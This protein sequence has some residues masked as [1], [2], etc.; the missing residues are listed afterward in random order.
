MQLDWKGFLMKRQ[1]SIRTI[2]LIAVLS[3][4]AGVGLDKLVSADNIYEQIQKFGDVLSFTDKN[5]VEPVDVSKL[6]E[7]AINGML[8]T[9]DPHSVY[10]PAKQFETVTD[11]FS[12]QFQGIG[13]SFRVLNDTITVMEPVGGGPSARLGIMS[14]D[15][16]IRINDSSAIGFTDTQVMKTLRGP[17]GTKVKVTIVRPGVKDQLNFVITRDVIP[18]V[19]ISASLMLKGDVGYVKLDR[20]S[21]TTHEE[22]ARALSKLKAEGMKRLILDLRD[23]GGGYLEEAVRLADLFLD[24]GPKD[25][26]RKIVYTKARRPELEDVYYAHTGDPY[27][28]LPLIVMINHATAS[29]SEIVS[30]AIQDWDRGLIVGETSFGKGL[31]QRQ[32]KLSDG[33]AF[34]ITIARYYTPSGRL[35][36]R[37]YEGM[38]R[39]AYQMEPFERKEKEGENVEHTHD[40]SEDSLGPVFKTASGRPVRGSGG[41]IPDY[42]VTGGSATKLFSEIF[43]RN[44]FF[45]YAKEFSEGPGLPLREKYNNNL[46]GFKKDFE[47][48]DTMLDEFMKFV[49]TKG[50]AVDKKEE[51]KDI[52]FIKARLK[53][54]IANVFFGFEGLVSVMLDVDPQIQKAL[55]LFP[56]AEKIAKLN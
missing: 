28:K 52:V 50:V 25:N 13:V 51:E 18:F 21:E 27:E 48:S 10:I 42:I 36:Q 31:V 26:P 9:L 16:I 53:G 23:D 32:M 4:G 11:Q 29:A 24:G 35:I 40:A 22:M 8:N 14:N 47:I 39:T 34:R 33:S 56:E 12:G 37:P 45:D 17:K 20:F 55:T 44:L 2:A 54:E 30:G 38:D 43:R 6:T 41:I 49:A 7:A 3:L 1:Y 5:Y 19:S 15:R 46:A